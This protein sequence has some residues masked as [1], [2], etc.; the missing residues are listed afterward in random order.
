MHGFGL[1][2]KA[3]LTERLPKAI[4]VRDFFVVV[5]ATFRTLYVFVIMELGTRRIL[6]PERDR[7]SDG[8]MDIAATPRGP[9]GR[10][11]V[12]ICDPRPG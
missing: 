11:S 9:A 5:T 2:R 6:Q 7:A 8:G 4:V 3:V 1:L 10:P 12:S